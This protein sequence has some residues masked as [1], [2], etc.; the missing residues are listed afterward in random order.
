M[1]YIVK[2][3]NEGGNVELG[4]GSIVIGVGNLSGICD[5]VFLDEFGKIIGLWIVEV[6]VGRKIDDNVFVV[7]VFVVFVDSFDKRFVNIV[8]ESYDLVVDVVMFFYVMN[9]VGV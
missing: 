2:V 3:F 7:G 4:S 5:V 8:G 1:R 6:V 9:I